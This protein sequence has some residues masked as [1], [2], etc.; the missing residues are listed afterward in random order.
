MADPPADDTLCSDP[1]LAPAIADA[2]APPASAV[3]AAASSGSAEI[4]SASPQPRDRALEEALEVARRCDAL[5]RDSLQ[6]DGANNPWEGIMRQQSFLAFA[7]QPDLVP[8]SCF[9]RAM[10]TCSVCMLSAPQGCLKYPWRMVEL[11]SSPEAARLAAYLEWLEKVLPE[12]APGIRT[13][14]RTAS[15]PP[16]ARGALAAWPSECAQLQQSAAALHEALRAHGLHFQRSCSELQKA[17]KSRR[18][19]QEQQTE[20]CHSIAQDLQNAVTEFASQLR[21]ETGGDAEWT[22]LAR[23]SQRSLHGIRQLASDFLQRQED[24]LGKSLVEYEALGARLKP[25]SAT[26]AEARRQVRRRQQAFT[27][28]AQRFAEAAGQMLTLAAQLAP[29]LRR[30]EECRGELRAAAELH[31]RVPALVREHLAAEDELDAAETERRKHRR[32]AEAARQHLQSRGLHDRRQASSVAPGAS[33]AA[34]AVLEQQH[35]LRVTHASEHVDALADQLRDTEQQLHELE[36]KLPMQLEMGDEDWC[37]RAGVLCGAGELQ[38]PE[39]RLALKLASLEQFHEEV[40]VHV[41]EFQ[42]ECDRVLRR[43]SERKSEEAMRRRVE[44]DFMCP[45]VHERMMQPVLAADGHTYEREAIETWVQMHSTSPMTGA[46][47]AHRYLTDNFALRHLMDIYAER[48]APSLRGLAPG[49]ASDSTSAG[50]SLAGSPVGSPSAADRGETTR[51]IAETAESDGQEAE[52]EEDDV[53]Q[54]PESDDDSEE[55]PEL[56]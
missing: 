10:E 1:R 27:Q 40:A 11:L 18:D 16:R 7:A 30:L 36:V 33:A 4:L 9:Q 37:S 21:E 53:E 17:N 20:D 47:L 28:A 35:E 5:E 52:G 46:P 42:A 6:G 56:R 34:A 12:V 50:R 48:P 13:S 44:P 19:I 23:T 25:L 8:P 49:A 14:C 45:I 43:V 55:W 15:T 31:Q 32:H 54:E 2:A 29:G 39:E 51:I 41:S 24:C 3:I 38:S 26:A 22:H